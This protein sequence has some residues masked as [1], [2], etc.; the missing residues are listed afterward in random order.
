MIKQVY[1]KNVLYSSELQTVHPYYALLCFGKSRDGTADS[2]Y[3]LQTKKLLCKIQ[4]Q[5]R[6]KSYQRY[7][8]NAIRLYVLF[9]AFAP[10][11][12]RSR[13]WCSSTSSSL[14]LFLCSHPFTGRYAIGE[15]TTSSTSEHFETNSI[16]TTL[17]FVKKRIFLWREWWPFLFC[18]HR[19]FRETTETAI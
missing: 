8:Q 14:K 15:L 1:E 4:K 13:F 19:T 11:P 17:K 6:D 2:Q 5:D 7:L 10:V 18:E 12:L 16:C 9:Q 3:S